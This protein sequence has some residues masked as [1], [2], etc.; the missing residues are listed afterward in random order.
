MKFIEIDHIASDTQRV[1]ALG[2]LVSIRPPINATPAPLGG[3]L[4]NMSVFWED[5]VSDT[6]YTSVQALESHINRV[7]SHLKSAQGLI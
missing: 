2:E 5:E 1:K 6:D 7:I 4:V 3:G